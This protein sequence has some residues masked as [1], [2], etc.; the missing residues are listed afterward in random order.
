MNHWRI[1]FAAALVL[2][3]A[4]GA[5][6]QNA[7]HLEFG[8]VNQR[9][10]ES[11][12]SALAQASA[13]ATPGQEERSPAAHTPDP[14]AIRGFALRYRQG[15]T[16][17]LQAAVDRVHALAPLVAPVMR[18]HGVPVGLLAVV[19]VESAG[20]P[21]ALSPRGA[22]G[23]WQFMPAT[24]RRYGLTVEARRDDRLEVQKSTRA[25]ARYLSDLKA[26]FNDWRLVL[27]AYNAGEEAVRN[28]IRRG[29]TADFD[30]LS[31]RKLLPEETRLYVPAVLEG[32]E[33]F[34]ESPLQTARVFPDR[35][36]FAL[37]SW[38]PEGRPAVAVANADL[39]NQ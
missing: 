6:A 26:E 14:D 37:W 33:L 20:R 35:K 1:Q 25:A 22:R 8:E 38:S 11:A 23:L 31:A 34:S 17:N 12:D 3:V 27:A 28:A 4:Q 32:M 9:L 24:A 2:V 15:R 30:R 39:G 7:T 13:R 19:L 36:L 18:E 5:A 16:G 29:G 10:L 21:D